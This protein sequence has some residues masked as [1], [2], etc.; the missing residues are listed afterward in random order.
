MIFNNAEG[1][2][3]AGE[4]RGFVTAR[5]VSSTAAGLLDANLCPSSL[6]GDHKNVAEGGGGRQRQDGKRGRQKET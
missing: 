2:L 5:A 3:W 6:H 1:L 4:Q